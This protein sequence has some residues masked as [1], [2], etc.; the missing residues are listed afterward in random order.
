VRRQWERLPSEGP[1]PGPPI[2]NRTP[3]GRSRF[4][5]GRRPLPFA[6]P[7]PHPLAHFLARGSPSG[8]VFPSRPSEREPLPLARGGRHSCPP[9]VQSVQARRR[10]RELP[11]R[12]GRRYGLARLYPRERLTTSV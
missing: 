10:Y 6:P 1:P 3:I 7:C 8:G 12:H 4:G 5:S 2:I 9:A 11:E